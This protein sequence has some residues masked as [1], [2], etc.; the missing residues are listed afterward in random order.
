MFNVKEIKID[1]YFMMLEAEDGVAG[2]LILQKTSNEINP[3]KKEQLVIQ[4]EGEARE[5]IKLIE[6]GISFLN[7]K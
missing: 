1:R 4:D 6:S 7:G 5:L 2:S 3:N